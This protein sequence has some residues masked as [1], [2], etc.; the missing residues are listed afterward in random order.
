MV[1]LAMT[2]FLPYLLPTIQFKQSDRIFN[3]H[4]ASLA[5]HF[6]DSQQ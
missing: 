5:W 4:A 2:A 3:F 1:K 6:L